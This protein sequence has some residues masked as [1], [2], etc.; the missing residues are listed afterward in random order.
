M[1][2]L[3]RLAALAIVLAPAAGRADLAERG[4]RLESGSLPAAFAQCATLDVP[5]DRE[6]P[7][8]ARLALAV[9]RIP[10]LTATPAPDP[11]LLINGGP[12]GSGIDLYLQAR[13]AFEPLR[14]QRDIVLV[15]QRGTGRSTAGLTCELPVELALETAGPQQLRETVA[16][17]LSALDADPRLFTT[18]AAVHD[19]ELLRAALGAEQWNLY[20][21]SYGTRVVQHY[22]RRHPQRVRTAILDGVVPAGLALGP[23]VAGNA[24][25]A[26]GRV[27]AR[28]ADQPA[29]RTRFGPLADK[30]AALRQRLATQSSRVDFPDPRSAAAAS[31]DLG[32]RHL[33]AVVRLMSYS[34]PTIALLPLVIDEAHA[35]NLAPLAAHAKILIESLA[36]STSFPMH[37]SV[38][39]TEDAPFF[40][41]SAPDRGPTYLGT[42]ILDGLAAICEAWPPGV[43]DA[44][45]EAGLAS[46]RPV[47]LLS[48]ELDPV[49]PPEYAERAIA[50]GLRN[51]R[52]LVARGH[53]HGI[54]V[55]GCVPRLIEQFLAA[56]APA[57]LAAACLEREQPMPFFLGFHGPGP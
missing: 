49:T 18:S 38:V 17:C 22:L 25:A 6:D 26:L 19:L 13:A 11:L 12:G 39:C 53:G 31:V 21:I 40:G 34:A 4:C 47:L 2:P 29:C 20:G 43:R 7:T 55:V 32:E 46:D 48:G 41:D 1:Q 42:A 35:G 33:Q 57:E 9:A 23:D 3:S 54:A 30:F 51:A 5:L 14:R 50:A 24:E 28:C 8:G 15:D 44:D 10:A 36:D 52:H 27:L 45:F 16:D 56:P 37:N